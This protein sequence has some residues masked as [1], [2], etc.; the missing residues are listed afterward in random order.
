MLFSFLAKLLFDF[1][2]DVLGHLLFLRKYFHV[3]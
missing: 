3:I 1:Q 2:K